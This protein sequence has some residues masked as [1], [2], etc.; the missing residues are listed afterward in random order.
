MGISIDTG[1]FFAVAEYTETSSEDA[2][3]ADPTKSWYVSGGGRFGDWTLYATAENRQSDIKQR[4]LD[5]ILTQYDQGVA[6]TTAYLQS[7]QTPLGGLISAILAG[8]P[9][10]GYSEANIPALQA[11][12]TALTLGLQEINTNAPLLRGGVVAIFSQA[13]QDQ[14]IYSVGVRY[15]FHP[16]AALKFEYMEM[17]DHVTD[18]QP[19]SV[20][21][22]VDLVY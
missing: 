10:P 11:Q 18:L 15:N 9:P 4:S 6:G 19:A 7:L 22:A 14:D 5:N 21:V 8:T 13:E 2:F 20:A 16:S 12:Y 1:S 3:S 17:D